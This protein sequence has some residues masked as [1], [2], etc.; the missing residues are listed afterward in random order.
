MS[1]RLQVVMR[2]AELRAYQRLAQGRGMVLSEWVR[3]SLRESARAEPGPGKE[4]KIA[5]LR[6]AAHHSFPA[7]D[8]EQMLDEI[9][10]GYL[11]G[12]GR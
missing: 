8:I 1:K 12:T 9:S 4:K 6:A 5:A 3:Q 10:S 11:H 7:P 2:D